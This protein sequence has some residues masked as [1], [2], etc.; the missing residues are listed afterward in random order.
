MSEPKVHIWDIRQAVNGTWTL[1]SGTMWCITGFEDHA[2]AADWVANYL[3]EFSR[4]NLQHQ[5]MEDREQDRML[6]VA[7]LMEPDKDSKA[8]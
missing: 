8:N 6:S 7:P 1:N 4:M 2:S 3:V 5:A